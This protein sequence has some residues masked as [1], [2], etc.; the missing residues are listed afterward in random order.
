MKPLHILHLNDALV[1]EEAGGSRKYAAEVARCM[2]ARGHRVSFLV[3]K[4]RPDLP[5]R[6]TVEGFACW[7]YTGKGLWTK[8]KALQQTF[9]RLHA[10]TPVDAVIVHFAY[11]SWGYHRLPIARTLPTLRVFH[12]PWDREA[13]A[14]QSAVGPKAR[15]AQRIRYDF[16]RFSLQ[17]SH[18]IVT[19]SEFMA[20]DVRER[21][22]IPAE[23]VVTIPGGVDTTTFT[24]GDRAEARKRLGLPP[25]AFVVFTAR[26]LVR[27]MGLDLLLDAAAQVRAEIP[28]LQVRIA[29]KGPMQEELTQQIEARQLGDC[30]RLV[31]FVPDSQLPDYYRAANLFVLPTISLE[32]F[33]LIILEALACNTPVLG[34]P[35]GAIPDVLCRFD[36]TLVLSEAS[37]EG[38]AA[39][40]RAFSQ[41]DPTSLPDYR[42]QVTN[43]YDWTQITDQLLAELTQIR[44]EV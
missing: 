10:E 19:L 12:G 9:Q 30:A 40:L 25:D 34:T 8:Q 26:R 6:E 22:G 44:P 29:G 23:K 21:F 37:A 27:R 36:P 28:N 24:P 32:G 13:A 14:E 2:A 7:R 33:G 15:I 3:P 16:E 31:G 20:T 18:R 17:H 39:G 41:R 4:K 5:D 43:G 11:T 38:I 35:V 1:T 42:A